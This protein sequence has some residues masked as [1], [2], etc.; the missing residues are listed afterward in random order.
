[1]VAKIGTVCGTVSKS[2]SSASY[3]ERLNSSGTPPLLLL[4]FCAL[5]PNSREMSVNVAVKPVSRVTTKARI[6]AAELIG[7]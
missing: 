7:M 1:M 3:F 5:I 4:L 2:I 6:S